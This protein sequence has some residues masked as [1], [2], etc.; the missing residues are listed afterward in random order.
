MTKKWS[1]VLGAA[2][3]LGSIGF[4]HSSILRSLAACLVADDTPIHFQYVAILDGQNQ[5]D[6]DRSL[7][8]A[9]KVFHENS[10]RGIVLFEGPQNRL[11]K[12]GCIP[13]FDAFCR[14]ALQSFGVP[15]QSVTSI[16]CD[17][18]LDFQIA[19]AVR[20]WLVENPKSTICLLCGQFRSGYIRSGL[21]AALDS[22]QAT[23][24]CVRGLPDRR[25]DEAN[26]WKKPFG[27][28]RIRFCVYSADSRLV[29]RSK[30]PN[31]SA[32]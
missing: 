11:V 24:V 26:W 2:V 19:S 1:I 21:D 12:L 14:S 7:D 17:G 9:V 4:V 6:G 16:S 27:L 32:L 10:L 8:A 3:V 5:P 25:F 22:E 20:Q 30:A 13:S 29:L 31:A 28:Q 23:R 18:S 15:T